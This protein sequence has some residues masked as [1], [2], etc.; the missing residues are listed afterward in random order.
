MKLTCWVSQEFK[1]TCR[2]RKD[3]RLL[4]RVLPLRR[5]LSVL[6]LEISTTIISILTGISKIDTLINCA[7]VNSPWRVMAKD[8]NDRESSRYM[9]WMKDCML[10]FCSRPS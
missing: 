6:F 10:T 3:V 7:G 4:L 2:Q 1:E 9:P 5:P 8:H